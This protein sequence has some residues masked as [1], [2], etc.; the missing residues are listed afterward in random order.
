MYI[1]PTGKR[2][3]RSCDNRHNPRLPMRHSVLRNS[4]KLTEE[5]GDSCG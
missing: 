3:G 5:A 1:C 2:Y 4:H